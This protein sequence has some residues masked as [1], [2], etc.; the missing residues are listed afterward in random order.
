MSTEAQA[1]PN[2][3]EGVE[4]PAGLVRPGSSP[5]AS[6]TADWQRWVLVSVVGWV[7]ASGYWVPVAELQPGGGMNG[8]P[9]G[10][11]QTNANMGVPVATQH[12]G[13][14]SNC[15]SLAVHTRSNQCFDSSVAVLANSAAELA[16]VYY[17]HLWV[18]SIPASN[19]LC[20]V[21]PVDVNAGHLDR[22]PTVFPTVTAQ[23]EGHFDLVTILFLVTG[24]EE[25]GIFVFVDVDL[26]MAVGCHCYFFAGTGFLASDLFLMLHILG[27]LTRTLPDPGNGL[28]ELAETLG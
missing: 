26:S 9:T 16:A 3:T 13:H 11:T 25:K 22:P 2:L 17:H 4:M 24:A 20:W 5:A 18:I 28:Y 21:R 8:I 27:Q 23:V 7:P 1:T 12:L 19:F 15:D 14:E 10:H 6:L